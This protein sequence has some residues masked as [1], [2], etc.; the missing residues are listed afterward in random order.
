M[1]SQL[2]PTTDQTTV[3]QTTVAPRRLGGKPPVRSGPFTVEEARAFSA[4]STVRGVLICVVD[5]VILVAVV[6]G[7]LLAPA[8][9]AQLAFSLAAGVMIGINFVVGHDAAHNSLT[10]STKLNYWL[11]TV[12]LLPALHPF[13]FWVKVHN[14]IHHRWTNLSP[15]DYVWNPLSMEDYQALSRWER[16][17]Y[18]FYRGPLG[19]L[20]YYFV[21]F[22]WRRIFFPSNKENG[23]YTKGQR[24]DT[25]VVVIGGAA[26]LAF[27]VAGAQ[28]G[29]FGAGKP[30]WNALLYGFVIPTAVWNVLMA[31]VIYLHH[32]HP[33]IT[34][35]DDEAEWARDAS[36]AESSVHV[37]FPGPINWVFHW[38]MEHNAHHVRPGIPLYHLPEAQKALEEHGD[39]NIVVLK[40]GVGSHLDI[41]R[42]CKL[43]D[44]RARRW[45]DFQGNFTS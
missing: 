29:W 23:P 5:V 38:I 16:A 24:F 10:P 31:F 2:P 4:R 42:R 25:V 15:K 32:T 14:Q 8:W 34:W 35:Y 27:L 9:W 43:Y 28:L 44:Y 36:Q 12:A 19:P 11:G 26:Y 33:G 39:A 30:W 6:A 1:A 22:W 37:I 7:A 40:W 41:V 20:L 3:D 13:S 45:T 21:E 17:K 18:R